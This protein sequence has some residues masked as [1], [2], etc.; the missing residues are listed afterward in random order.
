MKKRKLSGKTI[1]KTTGALLA[2]AYFGF[3]LY[4]G[5]TGKIPSMQRVE[6]IMRFGNVKNWVSGG[7]AA[8]MIFTLCVNSAL[9]DLNVWT[10]R[11][12]SSFSVF[13]MGLL[14]GIAMLLLESYLDISWVGIATYV[15]IFA[16]LCGI[17]WI[18]MIMN[19]VLARRLLQNGPVS[20][21]QLMGTIE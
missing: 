21:R 18:P 8:S 17:A 7:I 12:K 10:W 2:L 9:N 1:L 11:K 5:I 20:G 6:H 4:A 19:K 14:P 3:C 15:C 16:I 13:L